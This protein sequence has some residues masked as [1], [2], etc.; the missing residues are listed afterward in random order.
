MPHP[1]VLI[2]G[3]IV[4]S[5]I[6]AFFPRLFAQT[7]GTVEIARALREQRAARHTDW[8]LIAAYHNRFPVRTSADPIDDRS[9][10][11][12]DLDEVFSSVDYTV[13][14]PGRQY[15]YHLLR[16]PR[17][18]KSELER[19]DRVVNALA[20]DDRARNGIRGAL[21]KLSDSRAGYLEELFFGNVPSRPR[22][23]MLFP[24]LTISAVG[25]LLLVA[26][27]PKLLLVW[28]G[29]C[30][31]SVG[32][33]VIYKP[34]VKRFIPAIHEVPVFLKAV[35]RLG[36]LQ[37]GE[38][39]DELRTLRERGAHLGTL[40]AATSWLAFEPG[41]ASELAGTVYE[42]LNLLFL[43]DAN[44]FVFATTTL[45]DSRDIAQGL[46]D[47]IGYLDAAQSIATWRGSLS[48]WSAPQFMA[49]QKTLCTEE[50]FHPL[51]ANPVSNS[52]DV[53]GKSVLITGSNMSGKTTFV[54]T[55]GVNAVLAQTLH[56]TCAKV[57]SAPLLRVHTSIGR[58]DSLM[59]GKSY[60]LA[61]VE[62]ILSLVRAKGDQ[63]CLFLL[64]EV[65]RG[66]NTTERVAAGYAVLAHLNGGQD[67][68]VAAT[69]DVELLQLLR[70]TYAMHHFREQIVDGRLTFDHL[71]QP[72]PSST[73]N[74][75]AL[76]K[77]MKYPDSIVA[78]A[79][80]MVDR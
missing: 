31:A 59:D 80:A 14:E 27:W 57:W 49:P 5:A 11:D 73:R 8:S 52:L 6:L 26:V 70:D 53:D 10:K 13:S 33:Q 62:S 30:V 21:E 12:L 69:H 41:Q 32:V 58:A 7:R 17:S 15:L 28:L 22:L 42:Y 66:T 63:Q 25:C 16:S 61:E 45:R 44:A 19:L 43:L 60:Y 68:V 2:L 39:A 77:L 79:L 56:T 29:I 64:D 76:L 65:F 37:I 71:I 75:I 23:W 51:L 67:I 18:R 35:D 4:L 46:F 72:G 38:V 78:D 34:T 50:L 1:L 74:A 9:W 48:H 55:L 24:A 54:R 36:E 40:R 47:T 20:S 3:F